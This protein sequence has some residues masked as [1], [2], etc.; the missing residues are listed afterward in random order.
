METDP[1]HTGEERGNQSRRTFLTT[2]AGAASAA[3]FA[4]RLGG[5]ETL[6]LYGGTP[7]RS[8][9]LFA[10][11]S[12]PQY[13]DDEERNALNEVLRSEEHTSELQSPMYLVCRLLLEKKKKQEENI[14]H[15]NIERV[16]QYD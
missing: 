1:S 15:K 6:A 3:V 16:L 13:Y 8:T 7:V 2:A 11:V 4:G 10:E 9:L 14:Q 12:G 5:S